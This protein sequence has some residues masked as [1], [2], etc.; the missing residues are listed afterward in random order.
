MLN[1]N[2]VINDRAMM[3]YKLNIVEK[4]MDEPKF[5]LFRRDSDVGQ[6]KQKAPLRQISGR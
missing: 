3:S 5:S 2:R 1:F 6:I 4:L